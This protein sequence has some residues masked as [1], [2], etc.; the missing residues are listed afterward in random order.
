MLLR[1]AGY[2][3][4]PSPSE[5]LTEGK[6]KLFEIINLSDLPRNRWYRVGSQ[7]LKILIEKN[8]IL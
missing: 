8:N 5:K 1:I 3:I 4:T 7:N 2:V 6:P